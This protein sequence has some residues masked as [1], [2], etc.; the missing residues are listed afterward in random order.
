MTKSARFVRMLLLA[1]LVA[2]FSSSDVVAQRGRGGGGGFGGFGGRPGSGGI[3]GVTYQDSVRSQ[4]GLNED[5][6]KKL[7]E[8][9]ESTRPDFGP[10]FEQMRNAKTDEER[11]ALRSAFSA[12][13]AKSE[14]AQVEKMREVL[15]KKQYKRLQ[16]VYFQQ[17]GPRALQSPVAAEVL[18]LSDEQKQELAKVNQARDQAR[19]EL[20][21]SA[22]QEDREKF[23]QDW[24]AKY[25]T[26]LSGDQ[27]KRW[28][29]A[30]GQKF[31]PEAKSA[32]KS[33]E[34]K[35]VAGGDAS[36]LAD[37]AAAFAQIIDLNGQ[38]KPVYQVAS[39]QAPKTELTQDEPKAVSAGDEA[40]PEPETTPTVNPEPTEAKVEAGDEAKPADPKP[41]E[42]AKTVEP[43][44]KPE[45]APTKPVPV[46]PEAPVKP[47]PA[48]TGNEGQPGANER[49]VVESPEASNGKMSFNFRYAPWA[50]VL[51]LFAKRNGLTLD[52]DTVPP[53]SFNYLDD[54][55]YTATEAIDIINGYLIQ[56]GY[57]LVRRDKF[58]VAVTFENMPPNLVPTVK[59]SDL[60]NRGKNE[61]MRI[62]LKLDG[63]DPNDAAKE[64]DPLLGPQ[65]K[66]IPLEASKSLLIRDI[67]SNLRRIQEVLAAV[68][69]PDAD[70]VFKK[71]QLEHVAATDA[72]THVR[73]L[74]GLPQAVQNVSESGS[75][76]R[77][78]S[79]DSNV[80][81]ATDL[82]TNS[83]LV[84]GTAAE[85]EMVDTILKE[86]D[87]EQDENAANFAAEHKPVLRVYKLDNADA[88]E[89]AKTLTQIVPGSVVNED[90]RNGFLHI[91]TTA[92]KH[93]Q[94]EELVRQMDG[95]SNE[96]VEIIKLKEYD[97]AAMAGMIN[98]LFIKDG[99]AA[100][101]IQAETSTRA[102]I[103][104]GT[105]A[106]L[107]Q[108]KT[109]L[110]GFGEDGSGTGESFAR[111][112]GPYRSI[113]LGG[114]DAEEFARMLEAVLNESDRYRNRIRLV[115]PS[116]ERPGPVG[117][118]R[119]PSRPD[120]EDRN[121][122]APEPDKTDTP[123]EPDRTTS[124]PY[125]TR[126][127]NVRQIGPRQDR[128]PAANSSNRLSVFST[129]FRKSTT[130]KYNED[131]ASPSPRHQTEVNFQDGATEAPPAKKSE[132]SAEGQPK[133]AADD[134]KSKINIRPG[135]GE[136]QL[137]SG[138][139][140]SLND[141][142]DLI[143]DL[144]PHV[145]ISDR[146]TVFYLLA[147]DA[148][149]TATLI[150]QLMPE[151]SVSGASSGGGGLLD[152]LGGLGG[153]LMDMTGMSSLTE[154]PMTVRIIPDTR[155]NSLM[156]NGPTH[157]VADVEAFIKVLD[158]SDLPESMKDRV[159]RTIKVMHADVNDVAG[160][161]RE[162]FKDY[163][164]APQ[165][166]GGG[167]G[168]NPLAALMGAAT[169]GGGGAAKQERGIRLTVAVDEKTSELIVSAADALFKEVEA[170]VMDR[171]KSAQE[172]RSTVRI[173]TLD[174][175]SAAV[176]RQALLGLSPKI[177]VSSGTTGSRTRTTPTQTQGQPQQP[178]QP[179]ADQQEA[180]RKAMQQR[181]GQGGGGGAPGGGGR[182][183]GGATGGR[184]GGGRPT[185]GGTFNFQRPGGG[186]GR[187][188]GGR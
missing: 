144:L 180:F 18:G 19:R 107:A 150:E 38:P 70:Q 77:S 124:A 185:T 55:E 114:R 157:L 145:P 115:V 171:D 31:D 45:V 134:E 84:K 60:P 89:V 46:K 172:A 68:I 64:I 116:K 85:H 166:A 165:Q 152:S 181:F 96:I 160:V 95:V 106:Q 50:D 15:D 21:F 123:A 7:G 3:L 101:V 4:V 76:S 112:A 91:R 44:A 14:Q 103:F 12:A 149:E 125:N 184:T 110:L 162:I 80:S 67:G 65:G 175:A 59:V 148:T 52:L 62:I 155:S 188:R 146:W 24:N 8:I 73:S 167:R 97:A 17:A 36:K 113:P 58:L 154:G 161:V 66:V 117:D 28:E 163:L 179:S 63:I 2:A 49:P 168:G 53:G 35:P 57:I 82:R 141:I 87:V 78:S 118:L 178:Q 61:L 1:S 9:A 104:R 51:E 127:L 105:S 135:R 23:E 54:G 75:R 47:A 74:F 94:I 20:G 140:E 187:T 72:E 136:V 99:D 182:T 90:G 13:R 119:V 120:L 102:I 69:P 93:R 132:G 22:S 34:T 176:V 71:Y 11:T 40:K 122:T 43:V 177:R 86:I 126:G 109:T 30:Q 170:V 142:E 130:R 128:S 143:A 158:K 81:V 129:G 169:G 173:L 48:N 137:Y 41:E 5:Q 174:T 37:Q 29:K 111:Q 147:A 100:P 33:S 98:S 183:P 27:K 26:V 39:F 92:A 139:E 156:V 16:E 83:I 108:V 56:K 131:A 133:T 25:Q 10:I 151:A 159:P 88:R 6:V 164:Q 79:S 32:A 42:P 121:N 138:D 153:S 186:G